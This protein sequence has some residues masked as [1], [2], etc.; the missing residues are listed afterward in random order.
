MNDQY[1]KFTK[2]NEDI[3]LDKFSIDQERILF[4]DFVENGKVKFSRVSTK[5]EVSFQKAE[6]LE[7][8][9]VKRQM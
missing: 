6:D 1:I 4:E 2:F 3:N 9:Y 5:Y 8:S 7:E